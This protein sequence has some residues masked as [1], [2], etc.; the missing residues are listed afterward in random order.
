MSKKKNNRKSGLLSCDVT[1]A[2]NKKAR[3][4]YAIEDSFEAGIALLGTEV[5]SL[6]H[7]QCSIKEAYIGSKRGEIWLF[8]CNIPEYQQASA[9]MQHEP[10]RPRKLLIHKKQINKL[11]GASERDGYTIIPIKI[12]FNSRGLAKLEIGFGKGKKKQD[13]RETIKKRDW[14]KQKQRLLRSKN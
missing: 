11:I 5:K 8:N 13:K 6:R 10:K 14:D 12:Y 2:D 4:D 7:G 1:I 3:F 9:K